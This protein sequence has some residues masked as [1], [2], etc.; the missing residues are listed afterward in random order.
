[1]QSEL[2]QRIARE[3]GLSTEIFS[4]V[5][6]EGERLHVRSAAALRVARFLRFPWPLLYAFM[7]VPRL[8]RDAAYDYFAAH[9]YAWFG[10]SE[11]CRVPTAELRRRFVG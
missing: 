8:L 7:L 4:I 2:G 1:L 5:L 3:R 10:K 11:M 6:L 9:R